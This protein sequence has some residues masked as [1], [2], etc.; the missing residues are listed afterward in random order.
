MWTKNNLFILP[1]NQIHSNPTGQKQCTCGRG[2]RTSQASGH[3][4]YF[5]M[6]KN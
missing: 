6:N 1:G 2:S 5:L 3:I 4:D